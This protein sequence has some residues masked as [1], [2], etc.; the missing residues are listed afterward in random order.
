MLVKDILDC[1]PKSYKPRKSTKKID[2]RQYFRGSESI[3]QTLESLKILCI[4]ETFVENTELSAKEVVS[5][6]LQLKEEKIEN[7]ECIVAFM[8][9][10]SYKKLF[11]S[12][13]LIAEELSIDLTKD[14]ESLKRAFYSVV[15]FAKNKLGTEIIEKNVLED[16][17]SK[18]HSSFKDKLSFIG[19]MNRAVCDDDFLLNSN[20]SIVKNR[21]FHESGKQLLV[22]LFA[23]KR[24]FEAID[25]YKTYSRNL[26]NPANRGY[27]WPKDFLGLKEFA[28]YETGLVDE[29][30]VNKEYTQRIREN[31]VKKI[32]K[33]RAKLFANISGYNKEAVK[34]IIVEILFPKVVNDDKQV[35]DESTAIINLLMN[36]NIPQKYKKNKKKKL[37]MITSLRGAMAST[38]N[39]LRSLQQEKEEIQKVINVFNVCKYIKTNGKI[40]ESH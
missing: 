11:T 8:L 13:N 3:N 10:T 38:N 5:G 22:R 29:V 19:E 7:R 23:L 17:L 25:M 6:K 40:K 27:E 33:K 4:S 16:L 1:I 21:H 24:I 36:E 37:E 31:S 15:H 20:G 32:S 34:A 12:V 26:Y 14:D 2:V 39:V 30:S 18:Q 35:E 28:L 9:I